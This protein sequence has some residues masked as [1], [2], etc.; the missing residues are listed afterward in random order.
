M[1]TSL[2]IR[3]APSAPDEDGITIYVTPD[4]AEDLK[5][6]LEASGYKTS[7]G[8]E[9]AFGAEDLII[10]I[11]SVATAAGGLGGLAAVLTAFF[12]KNQHRSIT[13][14]SGDNE[15]TLTGLAKG[16]TEAIVQTLID[17]VAEQQKALD[18]SWHRIL[19]ETEDPGKDE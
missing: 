13:M 11:A 12:H 10:A 5:A 15:I 14:K 17:R 1:T 7:W 16:E 9:F 4:V 18:D 3:L 19:E 2:R 6:D 8:L